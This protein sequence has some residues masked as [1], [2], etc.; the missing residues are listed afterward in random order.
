MTGWWALLGVV[1]L[2]TV[3]Y[4]VTVTTISTTS[5]GGPVTSRIGRLYWRTAHRVARHA[6]SPILSSAG[7]MILAI[8]ITVWLVLLWAGW[9]LVFAA[10]PTA[11]VSVETGDLAGWWERAYFAGFTVFTLGIGDYVPAAPTWRV[12]TVV[13]NASGLVLAT[14]AITYLIPVVTAATERSALAASVAG[15]GDSAEQIV[16]EVHHGGP[17]TFL[18]PFLIQHTVRL[19]LTAER[20]LSY[21]ILHYFHP[22]SPRV[23][24]RVQLRIMDDAITL[25]RHG[26]A[27][28]VSRPHQAALDG[29]QRAADQLLSRAPAI[30]ASD[31]SPDPLP[32][33]LHRLR[34]HGVPTVDDAAFA[35]RLEDLQDRRRRLAEYAAESKW[36]QTS[37]TEP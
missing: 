13:A 15:L 10:S 36:E 17:P 21:P 22:R 3:V 7:P 32:M 30:V 35:R 24:L 27:D 16:V 12:L 1:V 29:A 20:H 25:I 23:E 11:V 33:S 37:A 4:D 5:A 19:L 26:L 14:A 31:A 34:A 18:E 8:T 2:T 28:E 9:T 6:T